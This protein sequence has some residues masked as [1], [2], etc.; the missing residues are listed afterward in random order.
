MN[1]TEAYLGTSMSGNPINGVIGVS[2]VR[3]SKNSQRLGTSKPRD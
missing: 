2:Y 3:A 1:A